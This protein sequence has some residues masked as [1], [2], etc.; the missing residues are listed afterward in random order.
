MVLCFMCGINVSYE[1]RI[2]MTTNYN[3][4]DNKRH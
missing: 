3:I 4:E 2:V 1:I